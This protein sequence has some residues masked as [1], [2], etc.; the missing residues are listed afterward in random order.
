MIW[1]YL[2][3]YGRRLNY[4]GFCLWQSNP[5]SFINLRDFRVVNDDLNDA[6]TQ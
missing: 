6:E 1:I 3:K 4:P 2:R 5:L